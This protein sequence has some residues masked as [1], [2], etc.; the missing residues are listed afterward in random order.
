MIR[1]NL[2]E[3]EAEQILGIMRVHQQQRPKLIGEDEAQTSAGYALYLLTVQ[4]EQN[5]LRLCIKLL[6]AISNLSVLAL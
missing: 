5:Y 6:K 4:T 2:P 1:G 3:C